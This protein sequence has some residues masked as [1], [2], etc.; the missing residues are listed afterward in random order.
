MSSI[1]LPLP[2]GIYSLKLWVSSG[3]LDR[4]SLVQARALRLPLC[5]QRPE[6]VVGTIS[7]NQPMFLPDFFSMIQCDPKFKD[8]ND[9]VILGVC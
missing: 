3:D 1:E 2:T 8:L 6:E 5:V 7:I 9:R 4:I